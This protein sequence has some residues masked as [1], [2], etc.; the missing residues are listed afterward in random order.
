[1]HKILYNYCAIVHE[2][3]TPCVM[4]DKHRESVINSLMQGA[5]QWPVYIFDHGFI[6]ME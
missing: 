4:F 5:L 1:M 3:L 2:C 6:Q